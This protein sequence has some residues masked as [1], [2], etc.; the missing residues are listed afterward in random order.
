[1]AKYTLLKNKETG[2][3]SVR[4]NPTGEVVQET[5]DS[6]RYADLRKKALNNSKQASYNDV[7]RSVGWTKTPYGWE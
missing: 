5:I 7:M 3:R 2:L 4:V 1:M 6:N